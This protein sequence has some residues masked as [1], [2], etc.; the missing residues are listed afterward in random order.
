[1]MNQGVTNP[2]SSPTTPRNKI[3]TQ[4]SGPSIACATTLALSAAS[5]FQNATACEA[6]GTP[7]GTSNFIIL[8]TSDS[9]NFARDLSNSIKSISPNV[10]TVM[11]P[12]SAIGEGPA[13]QVSALVQQS[14]A[15]QHFDMNNMEPKS[16]P[17]P[18]VNGMPGGFNSSPV[19][20]L[21]D[22]PAPAVPPSPTTNV[23]QATPVRLVN[24]FNAV[25][26]DTGVNHDNQGQTARQINV[27]EK[28]LKL[29]VA[30][31]HGDGVA[32]LDDDDMAIQPQTN[33]SLAQDGGEITEMPSNKSTRT[34]KFNRK[35]TSVSTIESARVS[36]RVSG[37]LR[38]ENSL[39]SRWLSARTSRM[40]PPIS[41]TRSR[42][43]TLHVVPQKQDG[44]NNEGRRRD[45]RG[46]VTLDALPNRTFYN[47]DGEEV[48]QTEERMSKPRIVTR[49]DST[50]ERGSKYDRRGRSLFR[51]IGAG[52]SSSANR[53]R[54][55]TPARGGQGNGIK[56]F[57]WLRMTSESPRNRRHRGRRRVGYDS[58][59]EDDNND[60]DNDNDGDSVVARKVKQR[61]K[62]KRRQN[63]GDKNNT[64][65]NAQNNDD[66]DADNMQRRKSSRRGRRGRKGRSQRRDTE[67][68]GSENISQS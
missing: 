50:N 14:A 48:V 45:R 11:L 6:P 33:K 35:T 44:N 37:R 66:D 10:I 41:R 26:E 53:R 24:N 15:R 32:V 19:T 42:F 57:R 13:S 23:M 56:P 60:D 31:A 7:V 22:S 18:Q 1:M 46:R 58:D 25:Q 64:D 16:D 29:D 59:S 3:H 63:R 4:T 12:N 28:D 38:K 40:R 5:S 49:S 27:Q 8:A 21:S 30:A 62:D 47:D 68:E 54:A 52:L 20:N 67:E 43:P 17:V 55:R 65:E 9:A 34:V 51:G 2:G 36:G 61:K 39:L